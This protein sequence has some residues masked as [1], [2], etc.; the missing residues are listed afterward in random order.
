MTTQKRHT[1]KV[2]K[3]PQ[4]DCVNAS[5]VFPVQTLGASPTTHA[6]MVGSKLSHCPVISPVPG[7]T[8]QLPT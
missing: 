4:L 1:V 6:G 3:P 5:L 7:S 8:T 2:M